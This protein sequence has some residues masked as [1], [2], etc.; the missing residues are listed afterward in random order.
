VPPTR[1]C[2]TGR[3]GRKV[4]AYKTWSSIMVMDDALGHAANLLVQATKHHH[5]VRSAAPIKE[6]LLAGCGPHR[7]AAQRGPSPESQI[8]A[9][10]HRTTPSLKEA[11]CYSISAKKNPCPPSESPRHLPPVLVTGLTFRL[12]TFGSRGTINQSDDPTRASPGP[13]ARALVILI[14]IHVSVA[15]DPRL[16]KKWLFRE[17][18]AHEPRGTRAQ[19]A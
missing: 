6:V 9:V 19:K 4:H 1:V 2:S 10:A 5:A 8:D 17:G 16:R 13:G 7:R 14:L 3:Q 18:A 15:D 12:P 11:H